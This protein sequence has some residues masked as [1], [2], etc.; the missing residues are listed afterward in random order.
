MISLPLPLP[1]CS[2]PGDIGIEHC[3]HIYIGYI[4]RYPSL[5]LYV[6]N[7]MANLWDGRHLE[8][9]QRFGKS[10]LKR[11]GTCGTGVYSLNISLAEGWKASRVKGRGWDRAFHST[12]ERENVFQ[13]FGTR[14]MVLGMK[15][16][17]VAMRGIFLLLQW[18]REA[19]REKR[20]ASRL[21]KVECISLSLS[22]FLE[23]NN[24]RLFRYQVKRKRE[25]RKRSLM[26]IRLI[27]I[28]TI[29]LRGN[30]VAKSR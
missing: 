8:N 20:D 26:E 3:P 2:L 21:S 7:F 28:G 5:S 11:G 1:T 22:P 27:Q 9:F 12:I 25:E 18:R 13:G 15:T 4:T 23:T 29:S 6:T 14:G 10:A 24:S 17:V 30:E 19:W 16:G